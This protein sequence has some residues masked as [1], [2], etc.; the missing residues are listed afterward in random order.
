MSPA[1]G[2]KLVDELRG[3]RLIGFH[4]INVPS[5]WEPFMINTVD[6]NIQSCFHSINVPSEWE[7]DDSRYRYIDRP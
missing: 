1:S 2:N 5:E 4:S 3:L 7:H 6:V